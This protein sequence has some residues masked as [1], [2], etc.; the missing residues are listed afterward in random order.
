M[1]IYG[2]LFSGVSGLGAQAQA[3][4]MLADNITNVNTVG[5]KATTAK[6]STLVTASATTTS[7]S[8]GGVRS[9]PQQL[10]DRQGLLL[11]SQSSTD[12]AI[13]GDGFMIVTETVGGTQNFLTRAGQFTP[14]VDGFLRNAGGF[15]LQGYLYDTTTNTPGSTLQAVNTTL[16]P[17]Y[18]E[19]TSN[20][21]I[22]ANLKSSTAINAAEGTWDPLNGV[23]MGAGDITADFERSIEVTDSL[24]T[25]RTLTFAFL[26]SSTAPN[27][28]HMEI[29]GEQD[30]DI[31]A[32]TVAD[33]IA[34]DG[35]DDDWVPALTDPP[36]VLIGELAFNTDGSIDLG[37]STFTD[38]DTTG[39]TAIAVASGLM[40]V[41]LPIDLTEIGIAAQSLSFDFGT[42]GFFDGLTQ[43]DGDS[44]LYSTQVDGAPMGDLAGISV[45]EGSILTA[46][47][48][49]GLTQDQWSLPVG[50]VANP[51]GLATQTGNTFTPTRNSGSVVEQTAGTNG[52]GLFAP[53]SLEASTIDLADEF[54]KMIVTQRAFSAATKIVTTS[55]E[56][57]EELIRIKR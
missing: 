14:D 54:A 39:P 19:V 56:M 28:W 42:A 10:I 3:M 21:S 36:F 7:Y 50:I 2:A 30:L 37:N 24:G 26:R 45:N 15:Y 4:G 6:F 12:L 29:Y 49:N 8:P 17:K 25:S 51:N 31:T 22:Q 47:Y 52:A 5:Y 48:T 32:P 16:F 9:A 57:L 33:T 35:W 27:R 13:N 23:S 55:D 41:A 1:S 44:R 46:I 53:S 11:S 18:K 40:P 38:G 20:V 43:F 34:N